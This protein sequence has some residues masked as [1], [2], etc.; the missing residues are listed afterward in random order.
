MIDEV[1]LLAKFKCP[2]GVSVAQIVREVKPAQRC[3]GLS[4]RAFYDCLSRVISE[5]L[6]RRGCKRI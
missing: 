4:G 5:E 2:S 3:R 1:M 6:T